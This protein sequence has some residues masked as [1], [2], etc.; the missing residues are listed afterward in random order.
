MEYIMEYIYIQYTHIYVEC[1]QVIK[2]TSVY[3]YMEYINTSS[4]YENAF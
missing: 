4:M 2:M 1:R 3:I